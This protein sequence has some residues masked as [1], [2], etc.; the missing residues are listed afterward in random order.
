MLKQFQ[1]LHPALKKL[2]F[3]RWTK[4]R[5]SQKSRMR[6]RRQKHNHETFLMMKKRNEDIEN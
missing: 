6:K 3:L 2:S 5:I 1:I 4:K